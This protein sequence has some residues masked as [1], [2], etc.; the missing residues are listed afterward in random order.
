M[1]K[2]AVRWDSMDKDNTRLEKLVLEFEAF[3]RSEGK[4]PKTVAWYKTGLGLFVDYL[5]TNS[6]TPVL[7]NIDVGVGRE[8]VLHLQ[9]RSKFENHPVAPR[10][11]RVLSPVSVQC[12]VRALRAFFN[13]LYKEGYTTE[14]RLQR[15]SV[16]R[17]PRKL[18]EPLTEAEV[19]VIMSTMDAQTSWGSRNTTIALMF[20]DTGMS[21]KGGEISYHVGGAKLYHSSR[22]DPRCC[23]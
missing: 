15:L 22:L 18:I 4:T 10:Q 14:N 11:D 3:N 12:Y 8:Y 17:A 9:K 23:S 7:G 1:A 13:W 20:L 21:V 2:K 5:R 16:P 6:I 19:A